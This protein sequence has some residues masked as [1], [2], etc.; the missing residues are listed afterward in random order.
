M[1]DVPA[2]YLGG[3]LRPSISHKD[4]E[5]TQRA[6]P[7]VSNQLP[8]AAQLWEK[9]CTAS[10]VVSMSELQVLYNFVCFLLLQSIMTFAG[11]GIGACAGCWP[12]LGFPFASAKNRER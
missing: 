10:R 11:T 12:W 4:A 7:T 8:T 6:S 1:P 5:C 9:L 3:L 2:V